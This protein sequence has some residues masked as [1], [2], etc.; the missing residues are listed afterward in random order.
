MI[1]FVYH[2]CNLQCTGKPFVRLWLISIENFA[3]ALSKFQL[4]ASQSQSMPMYLQARICLKASF[5]FS[6]PK[7]FTISGSKFSVRS[8]IYKSTVLK[9]KNLRYISYAIIPFFFSMYPG[10]GLFAKLFGGLSIFVVRTHASTIFS[11]PLCFSFLCC[12]LHLVLLYF[13]P[14]SCLKISCHADK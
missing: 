12:K 14:C 8:P 4:W 11:W 9:R 2:K 13:T 7:N 6:L 5:P 1:T 3:G 10:K